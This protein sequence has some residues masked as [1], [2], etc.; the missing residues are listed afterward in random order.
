MFTHFYIASFSI[1]ACFYET[2]NVFLS[3]RQIYTKLLALPEDTIKMKVMSHWTRYF[4]YFSSYLQ[5]KTFLEN[6][7]RFYKVCERL[8]IFSNLYATRIIFKGRSIIGYF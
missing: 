5:T 2:S 6:L 8:V 1:K 7:I 4:A 3:T